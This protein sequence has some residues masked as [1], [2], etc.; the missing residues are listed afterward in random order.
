ME[1]NL[2]GIVMDCD[3]KQALRW[4]KVLAEHQN[5]WISSTEMKTYDRELDGDPFRPDRLRDKLP[6]KIL[7]LIETNRRKGSRIC[8]A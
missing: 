5:V 2:D 3:S 1:A 4:V 8:L 7:A 6:P